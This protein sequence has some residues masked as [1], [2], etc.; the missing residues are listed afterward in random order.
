MWRCSRGCLYHT[1]MVALHSQL[2]SDQY[3]RAEFDSSCPIPGSSLPQ[4]SQTQ[5]RFRSGGNAND[6][7]LHS[8]HL[9][10]LFVAGVSDVVRNLHSQRSSS[11]KELLALGAPTII[12]AVSPIPESD[13][14]NML[15]PLCLPVTC[16]LI[17]CRFMSAPK[18]QW[19]ARRPETR[20]TKR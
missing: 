10:D 15:L 1:V 9:H 3:P 6:N 12:A 7:M 4:T 5:R 20:W 17:A 18:R 8:Q 16:P 2:G 14:T 11:L 19:N 13:L